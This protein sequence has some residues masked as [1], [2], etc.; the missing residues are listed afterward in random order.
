MSVVEEIMEK[1]AQDDEWVKFCEE[2]F[3]L[4]MFGCRRLC[5]Q[6]SDEKKK[7]KAIEEEGYTENPDGTISPPLGFLYRK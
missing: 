3:C 6:V 4:V 7:Q 2:E 5:W 1:L